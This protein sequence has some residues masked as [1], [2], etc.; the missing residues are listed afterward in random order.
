MMM[1]DEAEQIF[2]GF[3][4]SI[5]LASLNVAH[6]RLWFGVLFCVFFTRTAEE[7]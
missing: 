5:L 7:N 1:S 2:I 6:R 3:M 4:H